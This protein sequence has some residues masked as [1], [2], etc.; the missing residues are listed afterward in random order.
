MKKL[1]IIAILAAICGTASAVDVGVIGGRNFGSERNGLGVTLG[2]QFGDWGVEGFATRSTTGDNIN[3][4]T[5]G[6]T[7][8]Y[9][10]YNYENK[11]KFLAKAGGSFIDPNKGSN[12]GAAQIGLGVAVPV[13]TKVNLTVDYQYQWAQQSQFNGGIVFA[14]VKYTF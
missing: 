9:T 12:G 2:Q 10:L 13:D 5:V 4:N 7:G 6:A 8:S 3:V 11:A 1:A 14:G